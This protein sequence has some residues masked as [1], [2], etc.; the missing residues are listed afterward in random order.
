MAFPSAAA[1]TLLMLTNLAYNNFG[2]DGGGI[3]FFYASPV[4]FREIVL[5]KNLT[6]AG[7]LV[8][9]TISVWIAVSFLY[10]PPTL[11]VTIATLAGMLFAAP[12]NFSAGNLLSLYS[13]KKVDY[14]AFGRQR[15]AQLT[16]LISMGVQLFI[17]GVGVAAFWIAR[18]YGSFWI[19]TLI[20]LALASLSL[21]AYGM[22]L[23][24]IDD[25]ALQRR[26]TLVAE[27]CRA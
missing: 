2:G 7:I 8:L 20:L 10:G 14:S 13:P 12:L 1:Y 23:N 11:D 16:V 18:H 22:I 21:S 25:L 19:A 6:H 26:E 27:L 17:V 15:A 5:A 24:R 4:R 3:Q 9:E